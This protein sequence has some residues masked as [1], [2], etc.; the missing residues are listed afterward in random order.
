MLFA[1]PCAEFEHIAEDQYL[2]CPI[3]ELLG[4]EV[5]KGGPHARRIGVVAVHD[6]GVAPGLGPLR[7]AVVGQ[8][9]GD[10]VADARLVHVEVAADGDRRG[11]VGA[12]V[13]SFEAVFHSVAQCGRIVL[14][15]QR[16]APDGHR[17]ERIVVAGDECAASVFG[18]IVVELAFAALHP[19]GT[20]ETCEVGVSDVGDQSVVGFG[21]GAEQ[22]DLAAGARAHLHDAELRVAGHREKRERQTDVVVEVAAGGA[23]FEPLGQYATHQLLGRGLAVAARDGEDRNPQRAAVFACEIL[24]GGECV[25]HED[26][27][28]GVR[29][30][31]R[32][33][34]HDGT[35]RTAGQRLG[36]ETIAVERSAAQREEERIGCDAPRVGR[37]RG[38]RREKVVQTGHRYTY[39]S[40]VWNFTSSMYFL[41]FCSSERG[42]IISTSS[43]STTIY[44]FRPLMTATFFSGSEMMLLRVS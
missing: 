33:V 5:P 23:D 20:A 7:T 22:G 21:D 18:E 37:N 36:R 27:A 25:A 14:H 34:V 30:G 19:F 42:Q 9:G 17:H 12:V 43:V 41:M 11:D 32:R 35:D 4:A 16:I 40:P 10:G 28:L 15:G 29:R 24:Q 31:G 39:F 44:S 8:V 1:R 38:M 3:A 13:G 2:R 6:E 26:H